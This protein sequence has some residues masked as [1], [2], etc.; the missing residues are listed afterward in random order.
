MSKE[1]LGQDARLK[2]IGKL[3]DYLSIND[4]RLA[5]ERGQGFPYEATG[6]K[7]KQVDNTS[8]LLSSMKALAKKNSA[9][10]GF[11]PE[12]AFDAYTQRG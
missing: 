5:A 4:S 6:L 2:A 11:L 8:Q 12:G 3:C 10:L 9:T 7:I 1:H